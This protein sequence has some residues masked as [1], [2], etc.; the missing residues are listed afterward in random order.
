MTEQEGGY[1][2]PRYLLTSKE[3]LDPEVGAVRIGSLRVGNFEKV[4]RRMERAARKRGIKNPT[5]VADIVFSE[6]KESEVGSPGQ[7]YEVPEAQWDTFAKDA[8][9]WCDKRP[10][11]YVIDGSKFA[12][13]L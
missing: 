8:S 10:K 7:P 11:V 4:Q 13:G 2:G 12:V 1:Q 5:V 6:G 3:L 9:R